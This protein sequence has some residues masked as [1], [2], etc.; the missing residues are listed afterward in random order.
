MGNFLLSYLEMEATVPGGIKLPKVS[1]AGVP[2]P[3]T[4]TQSHL[5]SRGS[6]VALGSL[7]REDGVGS[8]H[9]PGLGTSSDHWTWTS[10]LKF[11]QMLPG[12]TVG[13]QKSSLAFHLRASIPS[14]QELHQPGGRGLGTAMAL[15]LRCAQPQVLSKLPPRSTPQSV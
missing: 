4:E 8:S 6:S 14:E 13:D 2:L 1:S 10:G 7:D 12:V 5:C 3:A 9:Q 11:L 15:F